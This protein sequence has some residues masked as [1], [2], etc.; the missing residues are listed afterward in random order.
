MALSA[1]DLADLEKAVDLLTS[2]GLV[3]RLSH[4]V[5]SPLEGAVRKLPAGASS[6]INTAVETALRKAV[7]AALWSLDNQPRPASRRLHKLY[8]AA[9]GAVG[10]A[11]GLTSL[12]AELPVST[13]IMMRAVADVA[14][15]EGF[16]L[17]DPD[18]QAACIEVFAM[19]GPGDQD[20]AAET[21]YYMTRGFA[22]QAMHQLSRELADIAARQG[23]GQTAGLMTST[24][25]GKWLAR[26]IEKVAERFGVVI[27]NK[28]AA[29]AVPIIG[30]VTGATLN[31]L[32]TDFYQDMALGHFTVKR[33]ENRYGAEVIRAEFERLARA[34]NQH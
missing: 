18:T 5:G 23:A 21:G 10:G 25:A 32:F 11:F 24:Q 9:S 22:T 1:Q 13:T 14:R 30:A 28:V 17:D 20:D 29:Q 15:G 3:A 19:G 27:T 6:R 7:D 26:L 4:L 31:T 2:P 34:R 12:L 33:L 8:A 16:D